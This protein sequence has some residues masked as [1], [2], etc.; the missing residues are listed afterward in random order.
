[1]ID[2]LGLVGGVVLRIEALKGREEAIGNAVLLV[3]VYGTLESLVTDNVAV[4]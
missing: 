2:R 3:E 4:G 1:L